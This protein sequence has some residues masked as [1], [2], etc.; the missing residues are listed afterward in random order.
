MR[1]ETH[2]G[3]DA[4]DRC[5]GQEGRATPRS[6]TLATIV[7][8]VV[9]IGAIPLL[10]VFGVLAGASRSNPPPGAPAAVVQS[11]P[12]EPGQTAVPRQPTLDS[13]ERLDA[14]WVMLEQMR[15][16]V[17]PQMVQT[18]NSQPQA[19]ATVDLAQLERDA[20][21]VDRMLARSP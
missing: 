20:A 19:P 1:Y 2:E 6:F 11:G 7:V 4:T 16:N 13:R 17:T 9:T 14:H 5:Y 15:V 18:M 10:I 12:V 21:A 8:G 3:T